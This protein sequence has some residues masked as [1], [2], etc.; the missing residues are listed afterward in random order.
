MSNRR[1]VIGLSLL[2][3]VLFST[4]MFA[5]EKRKLDSTQK[6]ELEVAAKIVDAAIAGQAATDDLSLVWAHQDFL[7]AE[8]GKEFIPFVVTIDPSKVTGGNVVMYWR[9]KAA[10]PEGG[11]AAKKEETKGEQNVWEDITTK[12]AVP[13]QK[14]PVPITRSFGAPAGDY[15]VYVVVKELTPDKRNA[16]P[17]KVS[18]LKQS[19]KVPDFW[20]GQLSTSTVM[21]AQK[22]EPLP[23]PIPVAQI[24]DRPY[25]A[26]G[27]VE[28]TP[29]LDNRL[30]KKQMLSVFMFV[31]NPK[32][33]SATKPDVTVEFSF[34]AKSGGA[35]KFFNKTNPQVLNAQ[36]LPPQF[37][38]A[39]GHQLPGSVEVP[40]TSFPEGDYR[41]EIK[42]TD[43]QANQSLTR[44]V[45]FTVVP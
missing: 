19:V 4:S 6:K 20:N 2:V 37:D 11:A 7:K 30:S 3:A 13:N 45:N 24:V 28:I 29:S 18:L 9:V 36:T 33:D 44:S 14:E 42:A 22:V 16:P 26:L 41:L 39:A 23:A 43:K 12:I 27:S 5:Q 17:A 32:P 34:Y 31:Y 8:A 15:D 1:S 10:A 21:V 35:E 25:A 38:M 40:L